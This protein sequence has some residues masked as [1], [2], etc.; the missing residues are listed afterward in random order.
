M[1]EIWTFNSSRSE[2]ACYFPA[3]LMVVAYLLVMFITHKGMEKSLE[4]QSK[5]VLLQL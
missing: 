4:Q 2:H 3:S 1:A 5:W